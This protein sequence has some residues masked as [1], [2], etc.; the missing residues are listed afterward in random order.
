M[1]HDAAD[2]LVHNLEL[3]GLSLA[4]PQGEVTWEARGARSTIDL[5]FASKVLT[6]C[7]IACHADTELDQGSDHYPVVIRLAARA[8]LAPEVHRRSW[9]SMDVNIV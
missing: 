2:Q 9:K 6:D 1:H 7:L 3:A 8:Q 4:T 5:A